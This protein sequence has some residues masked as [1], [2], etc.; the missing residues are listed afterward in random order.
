MSQRENHEKRTNLYDKVIDTSKAPSINLFNRVTGQVESERQWYALPEANT[1]LGSYIS[2]HDAYE[3]HKFDHFFDGLSHDCKV[4]SD[5]QYAEPSP[6]EQA[7]FGPYEK[8][9]RTLVHTSIPENHPNKYE[10]EMQN[11]ESSEA[12]RK[13]RGK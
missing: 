5:R 7:N 3:D 4:C 10:L 12:L 9:V 11:K 1:D 6:E 8:G 13:M 2:H